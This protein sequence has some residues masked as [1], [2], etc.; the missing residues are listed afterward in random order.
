MSFDIR[1]VLA[2][3]AI[4]L[5]ITS[6]VL[7]IVQ[8]HYRTTVRGVAAWS[9]ANLLAVLGLACVLARGYIPEF[10]SMPFGSALFPAAGVLYYKALRQF[11]AEP[12]D[13]RGLW[14]LVGAT[15]IALTWWQLI[16]DWPAARLVV[17]SSV[18]AALSGLCAWT[19]LKPPPLHAGFAERFTGVLFLLQ[20]AFNLVRIPDFFLEP[21]NGPTPL[22]TLLLGLSE[23]G[24]ALMSFGFVLMIVDKLISELHVLATRDSLTGLLNRRAFLEAAL[25]EFARA[26]RQASPLAILMLDIDHFKC[27]NDEFGHA[28]GDEVLRSMAKSV[29]P[30]LRDYDL[31][32]RFGGEEFVV[33]LPATSLEE[34]RLV[35]ERL[36]EAVAQTTAWFEGKAI[37]CTLSVGLAVARGN[38]RDLD[39]LLREADMAL[40]AAKQS[41]R[42]RVVCAHTGAKPRPLAM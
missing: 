20:A 29:M 35:A 4:N 17:F 8:R 1:T 37:C 19:V 7:F 26:R 21:Q 18:I 10:L 33:L 16:Y 42:N 9:G 6:L 41:G 13:T 15:F 28:A 3:M 38:H 11:R 5:S 12:A 23:I 27:I 32:A 34:A 14:A 22:S 30:C 36:R 24:M 40:Y 39:A 25:G 2:L 31:F